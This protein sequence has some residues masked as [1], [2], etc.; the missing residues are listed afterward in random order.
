MPKNKP[1][2]RK[3][4]KF[5]DYEGQVYCELVVDVH[6]N[7]VVSRDKL[8]FHPPYN[9]PKIEACMPPFFLDAL[10]RGASRLIVRP[11]QEGEHA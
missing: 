3:G 9:T 7:T 1:T 10:Y 5:L 11:G 6:S 2:Y 8:K 4:T